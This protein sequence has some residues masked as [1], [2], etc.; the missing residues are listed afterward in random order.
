MPLFSFVSAAA[1]WLVA[2]F[3]MKTLVADVKT[4]RD[5]WI[6]IYMGI[7]AWR[8]PFR[9]QFLWST[10]YKPC[11]SGGA[12]ANKA[13]ATESA[14]IFLL[15]ETWEWPGRASHGGRQAPAEVGAIVV[16]RHAARI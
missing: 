14:F 8:P 15:W 6:Y 5:I 16:G 13:R 10:V 1:A 9:P 2:H 7:Q 4:R 3:F 12:F 11:M